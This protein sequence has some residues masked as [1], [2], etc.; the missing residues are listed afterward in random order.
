MI[1]GMKMNWKCLMAVLAFGAASAARAVITWGAYD[2]DV[3]TSM[4]VYMAEGES[5]STDDF[6]YWT[7]NLNVSS[8]NS[9][10]S[11]IQGGFD[12]YSG[13]LPS[14][15]SGDYY[16]VLV[17]PGTENPHDASWYKVAASTIKSFESD[18]TLGNTGGW[19]TPDVMTEIQPWITIPE[20]STIALILLGALGYG[21]RRRPMGGGVA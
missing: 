4:L 18:E 7:G 12:A 20:P 3:Q 17:R 14:T 16:L 13:D 10:L 8:P 11:T 5:F 9:V 19:L 2:E 15:V 21:L 6:N 1:C